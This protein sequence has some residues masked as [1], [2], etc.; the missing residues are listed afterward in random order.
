MT[1][2][3]KLRP[4]VTFGEELDLEFSRVYVKTKNMFQ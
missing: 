3:L 1:L 4:L 2:R